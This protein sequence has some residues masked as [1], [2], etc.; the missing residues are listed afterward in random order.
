MPKG[1]WL[2][3]QHGRRQACDL[4]GCNSRRIRNFKPNTSRGIRVAI[5][6]AFLASDHGLTCMDAWLDIREG[7]TNPPKIT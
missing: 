5:P 1:D 7:W 2:G 6:A 4:Q 3:P